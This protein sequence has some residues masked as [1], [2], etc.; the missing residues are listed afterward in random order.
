V[1]KKTSRI[2]QYP[3]DAPHKDLPQDLCR[4]QVE[5]L[6]DLHQNLLKA[7]TQDDILQPFLAFTLGLTPAIGASFLPFDDR[8][9]PL[10]SIYQNRAAP[11][12]ELEAWSQYLVASTI[13]TQCRMCGKDHPLSEACPLLRTPFKESVDL[14]CLHLAHNQRKIG[15]LNLYLPIGFQVDTPTRTVLQSAAHAVTLAIENHHLRRKEIWILSQLDHSSE[16]SPLNSTDAGTALRIQTILEERTRLAREIHDGLA[17]ILSYVKLQLALL[18]NAIQSEDPD[19]M[20]E[21]L[22]TSYQAISEAYLD[23][24]QAIDDLHPNPFQADFSTWLQNTAMD[25]E[26]MVGVPIQVEGLPD[27]L[28]LSSHVHIQLVRIIQEALNNIRKH[29]HAR[30]VVI[31]LRQEPGYFNLEI[32]D[33][34]T[35]FDLGEQ[36]ENNQHGLRSMQERAQSIGAE[37]TITSLPEKGTIFQIQIPDTA[38]QEAPA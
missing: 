36:R 34:G 31:S 14:Y 4:K 27:E 8:N 35:G 29:A 16:D 6:S 19:R 28:Q 20:L 10:V 17:Q 1:N 9:R 21:L 13:Q 12:K 37:L 30:N 2:F 11:P 32:C 23:A 33:D 18:E 15:V 38:V 3:E 26:E 25:F 7:E 5:A 24:R 22:H